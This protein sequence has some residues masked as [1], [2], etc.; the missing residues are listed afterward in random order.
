LLSVGLFA[1]EVD[2]RIQAITSEIVPEL[3][4]IRRDIHR[5][6]EL[7]FREQ[8]TSGI[9][10]DY[11]RK[12]GLDVRTGIAGTGVVGI[13][14]GGKPG[15]VVAMRA[16]MD[17]LPITETTGLAFAS[18]ERAVVDGAEVGVMH[19]CGHDVHTTM[20]LGVAHVLSRLRSELAGTVVFIAQPSEETEPGGAQAMIKTG[21]FEELKPE[22]YFAYHVDDTI[23]AGF[24]GYTSGW[25]SANVD[26]FRL[27]IKSQGGHGANPELCVDPIVVGAQIVVGLQVMISREISVHDHTV[28]TVGTFHAGTAENIIPESAELR[29]TVRTYG[30]DQRKLVK[31][32]IARLVTNLCE[33]AGTTFELEYAFGSPSVYNDPDLTKNALATTERILGGKS[34][35]VEEKAEMGGEDFS[36]FTQLAPSVMLYLGVVPKGKENNFVH[37]PTF[38]VDEA[39]IPIGIRLMSAIIWDH[40]SRTPSALAVATSSK[41]SK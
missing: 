38:V 8:R 22:A 18:K 3:I 19:A 26:D 5:H 2:K 27:V 10:A 37:T 34:F 7:G 33:A 31:E 6:P 23:E 20:L 40:L 1:T 30:E 14:K 32:K 28:I 11:F 39:G 25:A 29:A 13:L 35:L 15:P 16:D 24:V 21:I 36:F 41:I 17:A 12:L 4:V 9:V